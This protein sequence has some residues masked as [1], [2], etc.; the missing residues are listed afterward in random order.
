MNNIKQYIQEK[1]ILNKT[2]K[3]K[4]DKFCK[5][6]Y[7]DNKK[8]ESKKLYELYQNDCEH[9]IGNN[10]TDDQRLSSDFDLLYMICVMLLSDELHI[11]EISSLGFKDYS[12]ANNP[13][14]FSWFE[15]ENKDGNT[16]LEVIQQ[17]YYNNYEIKNMINNLYHLIEKSCTDYTN[18]IDG[19]WTL[20]DE[21]EQ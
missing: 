3:S 15:E 11:K 2:V 21:I 18:S 10:L 7:L 6:L 5:I 4:Y 17:L 9:I 19:I 8:S 12:G 14:D 16:T 1:L 13:Y 20:W